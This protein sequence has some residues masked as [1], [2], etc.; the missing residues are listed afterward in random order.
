MRMKR[1]VKYCFSIF[2]M[3]VSAVSGQVPEATGTAQQ[4][5]KTQLAK[6]HR[7]PFLREFLQDEW[8]LWTSPFKPKNYSSH[9]I[10]KYVI[11]FAIVS[12]ALIATDSRTG[13][14][15]P[16]TPNQKKW[17]GRVSQLGAAYTQLGVSGGTYLLG[18][19]TGNRHAQETGWLALNA[20]AHS[21]I[22][23]QALKQ[24]TNRARP[25]THEGSAGFWNGG[26]SF[27]SGHASTSFAV[28]TVFAYEYRHRL[29]VP[30]VAYGVA[31]AVAA[32]RIS[33]QRHWVSDIVVGGS[34][35]FLTGRY[36]YKRHHDPGL[37]GSRVGVTPRL[38]PQVS[39]STTGVSVE[40][41][42]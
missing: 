14:I 31:G 38:V 36:I 9:T 12:G 4:S 26:N 23:T 17:S 20:M 37:P 5:E 10:K 22:V 25:L 15:L 2:L 27:P 6:P 1:L 24:L 32:S 18:K 34:T 42:F 3:N 41:R 16:N 33:A 39:L 11:P 30:I 29:A 28:A 8:R 35:G 40:W 13:N 7:Q 19:M 21:Q